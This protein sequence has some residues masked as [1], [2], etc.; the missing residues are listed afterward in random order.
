MR[1]RIAIATS[2]MMA[3][4]VVLVPQTASAKGCGY[5]NDATLQRVDVEAENENGDVNIVALGTFNQYVVELG[6]GSHF[7]FVYG[8]ADVDITICQGNNLQN[9][10]HSENPAGLPDGCGTDGLEGNPGF[11]D[12]FNGPGTF[13]IQVRHCTNTA[14][15]YPADAPDLPYVV[16][17]G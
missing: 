7:A 17:W 4:A 13:K 9:D 5:E 1:A 8:G 2:L 14:C 11:G 12:A 3:L 6:A 10:C 15:N 16:V